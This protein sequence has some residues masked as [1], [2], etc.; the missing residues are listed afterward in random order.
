MTRLEN[1]ILFAVKAHEGARRKGKDRAYILHPLE[2]LVIAAE[3]T[4]DEEVLAAAVLHDTVEDTGVRPEEIE[5]RFGPRV[6]ELVQEESEDKREDR[7]AEETWEIRKEETIEHLKEK[8]SRDAK[9][10]CLGDKL[11]NLREISRDYAVLGDELWKRFHQKDKNKHRWYY[12]SVYEILKKE[13]GEVP[14]IREYQR[15][16]EEVFGRA[17][18]PEKR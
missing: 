9:I 14:A 16:L 12:S 5:Q 8:A 4:N 7:L 1:A 3:L 2:A 17:E 13:F 10:I 18:E 11:S 15:L 6:K